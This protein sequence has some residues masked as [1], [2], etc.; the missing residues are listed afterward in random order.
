MDKPYVCDCGKLFDNAHSF[1]GHQSHC[2]THY[3]IKYGSLEKLEDYNKRCVSARANG[4]AKYAE[5][6]EQERNAKF[7]KWIQEKHTCVKCGKVMTEYFGSGRFCSRACA[8]S[9]AQTPEVRKKKQLSAISAQRRLE[10]GRINEY[11]NYP[12]SKTC[13]VCGTV[14]SDLK[15]S[16]R[17]FICPECGNRM[18][19]DFNA[20]MNLKNYG[21]SALK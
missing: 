3:L 13:S 6:L 17:V 14:K 7:A 9:R 18:D 20:S 4:Y 21:L 10:I 11:E 8:N 1:G 5:N 16:D 19:R 2:R 15:L 12:S